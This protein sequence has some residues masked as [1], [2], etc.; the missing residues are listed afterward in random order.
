MMSWAEGDKG[1][2]VGGWGRKEEDSIGR[3]RT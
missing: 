1:W 3:L 2:E